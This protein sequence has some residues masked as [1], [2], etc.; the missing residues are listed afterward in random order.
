[1]SLNNQFEVN[2]AAF[3]IGAFVS[4]ETV[5][6]DGK[7]RHTNKKNATV[8]TV[9]TKKVIAANETKITRLCI[10]KING[11]YIGG[12]TWFYRCKDEQ[13]EHVPCPVGLVVNEQHM[14][15]D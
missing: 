3:Y 2:L 12:C 8:N 4:L 11:L 6:V 13:T 7:G 10:G 9:H 14:Y 15:C 5:N 1:M